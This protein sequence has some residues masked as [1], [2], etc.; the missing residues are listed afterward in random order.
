MI[1]LV[2]AAAVLA[3]TFIP[4]AIRNDR[5]DAHLIHKPGTCHECENLR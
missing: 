3:A 2:L 5:A 4:W 1:A